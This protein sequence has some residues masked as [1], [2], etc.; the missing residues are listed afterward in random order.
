MAATE[1]SIIIQSALTLI[2]L[3]FIMLAWWPAQRVDLFRQQMFALRD[4][5][6][7]FA[8]EGSIKFDDPAYS[9]LR[10]LMNGFIRYAHNLTPYRTLMSFLRWKYTAGEPISAWS[11]SWE[12][13]LNKVSDQD[14]RT[15]LQEFHSRATMLVVGQLVLSPG[16]LVTLVPL[17]VLVALFYEQWTSLRNIYNDVSSKIPMTLLEEEAANS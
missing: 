7:D 5:L 15:K 1:L 17:L 3:A 9:R 4:E 16:M 13:A 12:Q 2:L 10:D 14:T 11:I 6:F 8:M